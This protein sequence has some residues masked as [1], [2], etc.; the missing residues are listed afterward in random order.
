MI[1][2]IRP[3]EPVLVD[4]LPEQAD[5]L[6]QVKWDGV[7]IIAN[8]GEGIVHLYTRNHRNRTATYPEVTR[9]L[10]EQFDGRR[11]VL[12]GEMVAVRA[13][14]PDFYELM[15]RDRLKSES[16]IAQSIHQIPVCYVV[17]DIVYADGKWLD[18]TPLIERLHLLRE[19]VRDSHVLQ[20]CPSTG[21]GVSLLNFTRRRGW[22]GIVIKEKKGNYHFGQKHVTWRK[23]KHFQ[24]LDAV[25]AGVTLKGGIANS[26]ILAIPEDGRLRYA[27]KAASG[28]SSRELSLLTTWC[29]SAS[30]RLPEIKAPSMNEETVWVTPGLRVRVK[31]LEWSPDGTLRSPVITGFIK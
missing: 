15:K 27:G 19:S 20:V 21:D 11:V 24:E 14:K 13:G 30:V 23:L 12:D 7:R 29:R 5:D 3:M 17:F 9:E 4:Q 28:L 1:P 18:Q 6:Y 26:L 8:I 2:M 22:E 31:F 10:S 25:V 16:K